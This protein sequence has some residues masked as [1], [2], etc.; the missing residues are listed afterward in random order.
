M[1]IEIL[2]AEL[3]R[4]FELEELLQMSRTVLGFDPEEVG[5]TAAKGSFAKAL[6]DHCA[7]VDAVEALCDA[8]L[9]SKSE[10][11]PK[12]GQ[13]RVNGLPFDE[14]L[15]SGAILGDFTIVRKLGEGRLGISYLARQ[16]DADFRVKVLR[17]EATRDLRGLHRF[18][19]AA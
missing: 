4:L 17:R 2:R 14:E 7:E 19:S 1:S 18:L 11:N 10:V 16:G 5:G 3:E 9:A 13:I 15:R 12:I 6:T 8:M